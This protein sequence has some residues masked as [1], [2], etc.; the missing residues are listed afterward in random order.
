MRSAK[1]P[2]M[3]AGVIA[4]NMAWKATNAS[5]GTV[6]RSSPV[7][8]FK[9]DVVQPSDESGLA[10]PERQ[11]VADHEPERRHQR[12][13]RDGMHHRRQHVLTP[14]EAAVEQRERRRHQQHHGAR[15]EQ[16]R[17][18]SSIGL[19]ERASMA[20]R[21]CVM[22]RVARGQTPPSGCPAGFVTVSASYPEQQKAVTSGSLGAD[23][24][25]RQLQKRPPRAA[26]SC[27]HGEG[28]GHSA[29]ERT[30]RQKGRGPRSIR[31]SGPGEK[32][33]A[34]TYSPTRSP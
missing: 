3:S 14:D 7:R 6:P 18:V 5:A 10:R 27:A 23:A 9:E 15:D 12:Y 21:G 1:A 32:N 11:R 30:R 28:R 31:L 20:Q 22:H 26:D 24:R 33:P 16:P 19:H 17:G 4:A 29:A 13:R 2:L 25:P 8:P 34:A